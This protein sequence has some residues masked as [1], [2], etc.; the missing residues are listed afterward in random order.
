MIFLGREIHENRDYSDERAIVIDK[1]IDALI[2]HGLETASKIIKQN[3][4]SIERVVKHLLEKET[5]ERE[6]FTE[7]IGLPPANP[8]N[9]LKKG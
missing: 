3:R 2:A 8:K 5:I 7:V 4:E 9:A 1:E 6:Q